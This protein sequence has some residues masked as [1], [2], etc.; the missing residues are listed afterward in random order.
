MGGLAPGQ[1]SW[2]VE[3]VQPGCITGFGGIEGKGHGE[4]RLCLVRLV[5][6]TVDPGLWPLYVPFPMWHLIK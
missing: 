6:H 1:C 4:G 3:A 5:S 2:E